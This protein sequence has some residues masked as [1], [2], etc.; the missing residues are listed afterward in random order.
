MN[1]QE[2]INS[3]NSVKGRGQNSV[4]QKKFGSIY[5][6]N[7]RVD[8]IENG[9]AISISM[10][11]GGVTDMIKVGGKR[12]PVPFHRVALALN[13]GKDGK[14]EY[15][16]D[17]LVSEIRMRHKKYADEKEWPKPDILKEVL[18]APDKFFDNATVF[19][20]VNGK[21][22]VVVTNNIPIESE[23]QVWCSCSDYYWTFEYYNINHK[24]RDGSSINLY[25]S[26]SLR[27]PKTYNRKSGSRIPVRN[28]GRHPGM[29]KHLMLL[30]AMLM[31]D[32]VIKDPKTGLLKAYKADYATF[33]R[34]K[35]KQRIKQSAYADMMKKY[36]EGLKILRSQR[37]TAHIQRGDKE[38]KRKS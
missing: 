10:I 12:T 8:I 1:L 2:L 15:T 23:V 4:F 31:K 34:D 18:N 25:P 20:K 33:L 9:N 19:Q 7:K 14:K 29:C 26:A 11:I 16:S 36:N 38:E 21:K 3:T 24:N 35:Q 37:N 5:A 17:Q 30:V 22:W 32:E 27:Y 13:V 28:P 6:F